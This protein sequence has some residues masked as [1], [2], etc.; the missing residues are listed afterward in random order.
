MPP[1]G[2]IPFGDLPAG[3]GH[4]TGRAR[5]GSP[6]VVPDSFALGQLSKPLGAQPSNPW[7][8]TGLG[9]L[10]LSR[11]QEEPPSLR[12]EREGGQ[13]SSRLFCLSPARPFRSDG[14]AVCRAHS[15]ASLSRWVSAKL[16]EEPPSLSHGAR[17]RSEVPLAFGSPLAREGLT[18]E[19]PS[20][21]S[22]GRR[23]SASF[24]RRSSLASARSKR[25]VRSSSGFLND[26]RASFSLGRRVCIAE[27]PRVRAQ[28]AGTRQCF[29]GRVP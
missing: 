15:C 20:G 26:P 2:G 25:A 19:P 14:G 5:T 13:G 27:P 7:T 9:R 23:V 29:A 1:Y 10:S 8:V 4:D 18:A 12:T 24:C 21:A 17:E 16:Q 3:L 11:V 22:L 6:V 28:V